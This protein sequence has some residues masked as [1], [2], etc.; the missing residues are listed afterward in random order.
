MVINM[1]YNERIRELR[2]DNGLTQVFVASLLHVG[3][4]AYSAYELGKRTIP[5]EALIIL[6]K[7]YNVTMDY[8]VGISNIKMPYPKQ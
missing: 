6:A 2:E 3:Q 7:Y 1:K 8:I 4:S 5:M